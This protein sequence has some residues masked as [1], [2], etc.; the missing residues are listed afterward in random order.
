MPPRARPE[1][2]QLSVVMTTYNRGSLVDDA[3]IGVLAQNEAITP[4][5]ELIVVDNNSTDGTRQNIERFTRLDGRVRYIFE[6]RQG[7]SYGR[8]T[9]IREARAPLIAFIDD[10]VRAEPDWVATIVRA[11]GEHADADLVGGRV[12]PRWPADPPEWLTRDHWSPL[13]LVD[14]GEVPVAIDAEH[15]VCLVAANLAL[16][17]SV[18]DLV[19]GFA[20]DFG[21]VKDG[22][23]SVEDH[24]LLLRVLR[25]GRKAYYD[26]R[27]VVHA[28]IQPNRLQRSYHRR[29]HTGHGHF[30]ALLRSERME[31]TTVGTLFGVPA[32]LYRQAVE[33]LVGW[34]RAKAI[35][36]PGRAFEHEVHLHFFHGFFR[37][38]RREFL[39][40]RQRRA[41]TEPRS[42]AIGDARE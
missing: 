42:V 18:L 4:P 12:L 27:I 13:A 39:K 33:D 3:L 7:A 24:E 10:D 22:V 35:G 15:P 1:A 36:K 6:P 41:L 40:K 34:V 2:P 11:F 37:T 23:G 32:H 17:R 21:L 30:H 5:F 16:R 28:E 31:Q 14:H 29:W 20:P 26:P 25:A 19:G 9:G 8:N 38:R